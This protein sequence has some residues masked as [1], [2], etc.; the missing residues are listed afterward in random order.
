M[1]WPRPVRKT[2]APRCYVPRIRLRRAVSEGKGHHP[3][4]SYFLLRG[5]Q[6]GHHHHDGGPEAGAQKADQCDCMS[7]QLLQ[8]NIR[9]SR[10]WR[11]PISSRHSPPPWERERPCGCRSSAWIWRIWSMCISTHEASWDPREPPAP[12]PA[13]WSC[14]RAIEEKMQQDR[15]DDR[16]EDGLQASAIRYPAR[17]IPG[18]WTPVS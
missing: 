1:M 11:L 3:S 7:W 2:G 14:L 18:R 13:S 15:S 10:P 4:G 16:R 9:T 8:I 5:R 12:R 17:P 6:H